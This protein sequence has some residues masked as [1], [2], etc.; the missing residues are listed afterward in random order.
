[1]KKK[2]LGLFFAAFL[3]VSTFAQE[4]PN[5]VFVDFGSTIVGVLL[6]GFGI[7]LGYERGIADNLSAIITAGYIGYKI[8]KSTVI[9]ND[10]EYLGVSGGVHLR[11]YPLSE[12]VK[13]WFIDIGGTYSYMEITFDGIKAESN[14]VEVA[15]LTGWKFV[16]GESGGF[17]LEPGLGYRFIFGDI[18]T[19]VGS[20]ELPSMSGFTLWL[21][22]GWAF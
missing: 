18:K 15:A 1:M 8:E 12:A 3:S 16:F 21:G 7:G 2:V 14:V 5:A 20:A 11:Y 13:R 22:M 10:T 6:G 4:V 9:V 17:F 19:P